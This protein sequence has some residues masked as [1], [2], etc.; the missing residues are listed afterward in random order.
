MGK[1]G[2]KY[3]GKSSDTVTA[4]VTAI[5]KFITEIFFKNYSLNIDPMEFYR[6][7]FAHKE[8]IGSSLPLLYLAIS[9]RKKLGFSLSKASC[10]QNCET[11]SIFSSFPITFFSS[12]QGCLETLTLSY[13]CP[14]CSVFVLSDCIQNYHFTFGF[15][16]FSSVH[17]V[18]LFIFVLISMH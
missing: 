10:R 13:C 5:Q 18:V 14:V 11:K 15:Q 17:S 3:E 12:C 16:Q 8:L 1:K 7:Y 4:I 6:S 2:E 9:F